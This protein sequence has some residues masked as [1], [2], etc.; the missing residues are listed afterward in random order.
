MET[1]V[2]NVD[3]EKSIGPWM[4]KTV[5]MVDYH[6]HELFQKEN[7]DISKE[8]MIVLKKLH[9]HGSLNQNRLASM[10]FRDKSS[11]TRLLSNMERKGY[12]IKKQSVEDK[13]IKEV[14][15]TK[16]GSIIFEKTK[17][18]IKKVIAL[19]ENG[20]ATTEKEMIITMLKR[21]QANFKPKM[22]TL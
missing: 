5:K 10:T 8:Q 2:E 21:V 3:F 17:P 19:M 22:H 20:F 11:L 12:I 16:E 7:L 14:V 9:E 4:G 6:M 15:L 13:R 1:I 18:I